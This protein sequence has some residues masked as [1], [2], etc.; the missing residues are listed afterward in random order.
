[1]IPIKSLRN[2]LATA[3]SVVAFSVAIIML[4]QTTTPGSLPVVTMSVPVPQATAMPAAVIAPTMPEVIATSS[5][6]AEAQA[7]T[8]P[9]HREPIHTTTPPPPLPKTATVVV[10]KNVATIKAVPTSTQTDAAY[11]AEIARLIQ[12]QTN[13]FRVANKLSPL[14]SDGA[15]V[16]NA[17]AYSR[18]L[19]AGHFLS[20]TDKTGCDMTCRFTRAGYTNAWAWGENLADLTFSERPTAAYVANYF[21]QAWEK[22]AGHRENLLTSKYT[23]T[24]I[25]VAMDNHSIYVTVQFS[26]PK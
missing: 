1:M 21:M 23:N 26:E 7:T 9:S 16:R 24:G 12:Q 25:G 13:A 11:M 14:T 19:L 15:L 4:T 22:S 10:P 17:T 18:T 5:V 2:D 20:H 8:T 3:C 6:V